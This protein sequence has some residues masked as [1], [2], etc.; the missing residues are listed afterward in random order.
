MYEETHGIVD[1]SMYDPVFDEKFHM[2]TKDTKWW[3]GSEP[4]W[5]HV[6]RF[7]LKSG[8]YYWPGSESEVN[9]LRPDKWLRYSDHTPFRKRVDDV[10]DWFTNDKL[11]F[12]T[13]YFPEPDH[14]GHA[15]GPD[16]PEIVEKIKE[17]DGILG[18]LMAK[19]EEKK[20]KDKVNVIVTSD[21]GMFSIDVKN[22]VRPNIY[23]GFY[24]VSRTRART[25][26]H[27]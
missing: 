20:L 9:G 16:S 7:N 10:M 23:L 2:G 8:T 11:N 6:K 4:I 26:T 24:I 17:M 18:Y 21:H 14:T 3:N 25:Y 22:K 19:L 5:C 1:N 15:H 13:L 27:I 12:I